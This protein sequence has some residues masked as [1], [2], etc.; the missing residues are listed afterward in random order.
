[1]GAGRPLI[2]DPAQTLAKWQRV[3][4]PQYPL[5]ENWSLTPGTQVCTWRCPNPCW[6]ALINVHLLCSQPGRS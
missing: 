2:L 4:W 5:Q 1:M 6:A 3:L